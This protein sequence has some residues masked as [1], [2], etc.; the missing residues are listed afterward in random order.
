[1]TSKNRA[2]HDVL[3]QKMPDYFLF[4]NSLL[5][6]ELAKIPIRGVKFF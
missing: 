2:K 3:L 1:M 6:K 4:R 5:Y